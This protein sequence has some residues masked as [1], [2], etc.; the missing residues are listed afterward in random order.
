MNM[1]KTREVSGVLH[2]MRADRTAFVEVESPHRG[3]ELLRKLMVAARNRGHYHRYFS[4]RRA[5]LNAQT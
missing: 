4:L 1:T 3:R 2:P 5:W